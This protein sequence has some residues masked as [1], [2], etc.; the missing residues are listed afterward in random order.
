VVLLRPDMFPK[1]D[2]LKYTDG[3]NFFLIAGPCVVEGEEMFLQ[4]QPNW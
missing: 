4:Q 2:K 3:N 1:L